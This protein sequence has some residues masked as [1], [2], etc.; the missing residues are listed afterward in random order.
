MFNLQPGQGLGFPGS[1][2]IALGLGTPFTVIII[3]V[4]V[5]QAVSVPGGGIAPGAERRFREEREIREIILIIAK[6]GIIN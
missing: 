2:Q 1:K 4:P 5:E 6:S 3:I